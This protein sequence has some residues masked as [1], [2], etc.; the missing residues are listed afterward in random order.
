MAASRLIILGVAVAAAGGAGY[1]AKNMVAAPPPQVIV[2][3]ARRRRRSR[4]QRRA[5]PDRRRADGR[6]ARRTASAWQSWPAERRQREFH[7][8]RR[9]ARGAGEAA[10]LRS[11]ASPC[12][13]ASRCARSKLIG[14]GQSFMSSILPVR[15]ARGRHAD[16]GRHLG[17]RL[18]PAQ[19][20]CRRHHDPPLRHRRRRR[21]LHHRDHPQEH[22]G[23]GDRPDH[24][25][26]RGRQEASRSARPPRWN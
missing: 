7:H 1:V 23:P 22:P 21:R 16:R 13:P 12:I 19:R 14:E 11:P 9:R 5:G 15:Q 17:R 8:P 20:L 18:H 3:Q 25:G 4:L 10:R 24:P 2:E 6:A 26:G